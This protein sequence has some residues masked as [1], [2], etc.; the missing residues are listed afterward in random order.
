MNDCFFHFEGDNFVYYNDYEVIGEV[1]EKPSVKESIFFSWIEANKTYPEAKTLTYSKFISMF[2]YD[3]R[4]RRWSPRK[5]GFN[6]GR[7][8]WAPPSTKELYYLRM[9]LTVIRVPTWYK[10]IKYVGG[11]VC[12]SFMDACFE[13]G[14]LEDDNKYVV[15]IEEAKDWG[16]DHFL[17]KLFITMLL[18]ST[19]NR[20]RQVWKIIWIWLC[21]TIL[22]EPRNKSSDKG[23]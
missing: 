20:P 11:K 17:R 22:Y 21:H 4:Y 16:S 14:F 15:A 23:N 3:K 19:I 6:I 12:D 10:D 1:L 18:S 5:R 9:M 8:I 2:V 13:M 7:L